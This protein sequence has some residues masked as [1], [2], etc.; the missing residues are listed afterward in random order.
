[1]TPGSAGLD[2]RLLFEQLPSP[3]LLM[4]ADF[5]IVA[6]ND[7]Y[8][9]AT[10]IDP[11]EVAGK[12]MFE[13]FPDNPDDPDADGVGNLRRS[14]QTVVETGRADAMALQRYDIPGRTAGSSCGTGVR[15]TARSWTRP[16]G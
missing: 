1:M 3:Y 6:I 8:A 4:T 10:M 7:A 16:G 14:L 12:P 5:T 9:R 15:S 2:Y 11:A 13:V